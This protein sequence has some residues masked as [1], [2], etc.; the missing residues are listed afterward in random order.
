MAEQKNDVFNTQYAVHISASIVLYNS[1]IEYINK[2]INS[3]VPSERRILFLIDNSPEKSNFD[4]VYGN[5][6]IKYY[7]IGK[8]VGYGSG[9]N[10]ALK[11]AIEEKTK[12][13][14]ILNPDLQF[15][16]DSIDKIITFMD[17]NEDIVELMPKII[18]IN[19]KIQYLCK[20]LPTPFDLIFRRF[21]S[22]T[23]LFEKS[24]DKYVLKESGYNKILNIPCLSGCFMFLRVKTI[25]TNNIFFDEMFFL[26]CEDFDYIRRLHKIGKTVYYPYV[27][28][29]HIHTRGSYKSKRLLVEHIKSAIKYFNKWGWIFDKERKIINK[30]ILDNIKSF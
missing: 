4:F 29:T 27:N 8:N 1:N 26:Y 23:P 7:F 15:E 24:N 20:L 18:D 21:F 17:A 3:Y 6:N 22:K 16:P 19:G 14:I 11:M 9:H 5:N 10:I 2:V 25:E 13:H 28:I 12:Y 30:R